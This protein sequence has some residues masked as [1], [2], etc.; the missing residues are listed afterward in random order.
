[1]AD[2]AE[3]VTPDG[4]SP[5][6]R[7]C[8]LGNGYEV[9]P[10]CDK[11]P[12][13]PGWRKEPM[14]EELLSRIE[15]Q[16][17]DH[18]NTGVRTGNLAV[19]D[20]DLRNPDHAAAIKGTIF[21]VLGHNYVERVGAKGFALCYYNL[22]PISKITV[23][24]VPEGAKES[25]TLFEIL[26]NG[27][28]MAAYGIHPGTRKPY[29][30]TNDATGDDLLG[31][32][33]TKLPA[34]SPDK[35]RDAARAVLTALAEMGYRDVEVHGLEEHQHEP[36]SRN[37]DP[38]SV[39][40]LTG[41][42]RAIPPD[43]PREKWRSILWATRDTNLVP[44][45]D[46]DGR[47]GLLNE[48]SSGELGGAEPPDSYEGYEDVERTYY[49][50]KGSANPVTVGTIYKIAQQQGFEGGPP[51]VS[52]M[53]M[54]LANDNFMESI[55]PPAADE[56]CESRWPILTLRG[57]EIFNMPPATMLIPGWLRDMGLTFVLAQ[58][59][60][61]KTVLA[62]DAALCM[63]TDRDW[64]GEPVT[65]GLHAVY[66]AG[67]DVENTAQHIAAWCKYHNNGKV[68]ERFTFIKDVPDLMDGEDCAALAKHLGTFVPQGKRG[69]IFVDTWQRATS[70]APDGQNSDRDMGGAVKKLEAL[71]RAFG[72]PA[73]CCCHPPK[74]ARA[75]VSGSFVIE[76]S[77]TAIWHLSNT[78]AGLKVEVIRIKGPGLGNYKYLAHE[79]VMLDRR[80]ERG[81]RLTGIVAICTGGN[82]SNALDARAAERAARL[83]VLNTVLDLLDRGIAVVR[84]SGS[85]QKPGDVAKAVNERYSLNLGKKAVS[86]HLAA[87]ERDG[88]LVYA[89]ADKN[90][91][92]KAGYQRP[93]MVAAVAESPPKGFPNDAESN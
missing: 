66:V 62:V 12:L 18:T 13:W 61:G 46:D 42:L 11:R 57:E 41:A 64:M 8:L 19:V 44:H 35:L 70:A 58:R 45:M 72:G 52:L 3:G 24:G 48:W 92:G 47:I 37:G 5:A 65:Q 56:P 40:W 54:A 38:A 50:G 60:T 87:L 76:N 22:T 2:L 77:S 90:H 29:V 85:G 49:S 53:A 67:E 79:T 21:A 71:A 55:V 4:A 26:G 33:L 16:Y 88:K 89:Q 34:V 74:D 14:T 25:V 59:G 69:V 43:V 80:D 75:T 27:Q 84:V 36:S 91:R 63:A 68:P 7:R 15:S 10:I 6:G 81:Q 28:Q 23:T 17:P 86:D 32:P 39:E 93:P 30:W 51:H 20:I 73:V 31:T 82:L 78:D 1:M 9:L 83:A